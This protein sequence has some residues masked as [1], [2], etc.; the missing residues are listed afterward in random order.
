MDER[1]YGVI[2]VAK[3]PRD[4]LLFLVV[5]HLEGHWSFSKGR[6]LGEETY[7]E[8]ALRELRE[9]TG[10]SECR[11]MPSIS[12]SDH[13]A[14]SRNGH[15]ISKDVKY[16][17]GKVRKQPVVLEANKIKDYRWAPFKEA[18][19]LITYPSAKKILEECIRQL[20]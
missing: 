18:V 10:I 6:A 17:V 14:F 20:G 16:F 19:H 8:T 1:S 12:F 7:E 3:G 5:Q 2:P 11:L 15:V 4:S 13:Y 9:E